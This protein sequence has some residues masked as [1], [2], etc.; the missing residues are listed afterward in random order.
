MHRF[1]KVVASL[2]L[3][4]AGSVLAA[5][6]TV[7][8]SKTHLCCGSCVKGAEK[9]VTSAGAK[10]TCDKDAG[11]VTITAPDAATAQKAVDA[12]VAAGY[13]GS[14]NGGATIAADKTP[15]GSVKSAEVS[16]I[17]NCCKKCTTAINGTVKKV[18]GAK[19]EIAPKAETFTI[20]GN[21]DAQKLSQALHEAGLNAKIDPK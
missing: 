21:F 2:S 8:M 19:G 6:S 14:V 20:T 15:A 7:T 9:A 16:G 5:D 1:A 3:F 18:D 17:H 13:Y 10:A 11:T 4:V 12:L